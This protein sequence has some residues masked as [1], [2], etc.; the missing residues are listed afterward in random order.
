M[1]EV[2]GDVPGC[3][4]GGDG[5]LALLRREEKDDHPKRGRDRQSR[6]DALEGSEHDDYV[7][8]ADKA[9]ADRKT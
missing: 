9:E 7:L 5:D 8:F 6:A 3:S 2:K 4:E 1:I